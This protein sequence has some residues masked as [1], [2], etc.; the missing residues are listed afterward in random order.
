MGNIY[1]PGPMEK[2][3]WCN[4]LDTPNW[5]RLWEEINGTP[6]QAGWKPIAMKMVRK[7]SRQKLTYADSPWNSGSSLIFRKTAI[8]KMKPLLEEYGELLP[9]ECADAELWVYNP[10]VLIDAL[11]KKASEGSRFA[12]GRLMII[13]KYV[14]YPDVV[15]GVDIFK[16]ANERASSTFVTDR[17]VDLWKS[18]GLIGLRFDKLWSSPE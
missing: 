13:D 7:A 12:D 15:K 17:F 1:E 4:A 10:T 8:D 9:L 2:T 11:D 18:S 14:F 5:E 6:R 16:L 3:E